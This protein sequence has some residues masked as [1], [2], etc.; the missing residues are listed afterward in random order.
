M[1]SPRWRDVLAS[2]ALL[3][4]LMCSAIGVAMV[5]GAAVLL[6]ATPSVQRARSR[7]S[8]RR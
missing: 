4:S 3:A 1:T 2:L 5:V 6:F 8:L 7:S